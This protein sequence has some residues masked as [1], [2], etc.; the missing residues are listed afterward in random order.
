VKSFTCV[1]LVVWGLYRLVLD[2][3]R[4]SGGAPG[5]SCGLACARV[6]PPAPSLWTSFLSLLG[7]APD[8]ARHSAPTP[9]ATPPPS[10]A[11]TRLSAWAPLRCSLQGASWKMGC[12]PLG[13]ALPSPS[14]SSS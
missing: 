7:L 12:P 3:S 10:A 13:P 11:V 1:S 6:V 5:A 9:T 2:T 4:L 8:P 14:D